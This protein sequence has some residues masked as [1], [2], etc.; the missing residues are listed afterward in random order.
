M[1]FAQRLPKYR[2]IALE[3]GISYEN[4]EY[5]GIL[6]SLQRSQIII[7]SKEISQMKFHTLTFVI[8]T[9][10]WEIENL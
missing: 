10:K 8:I 5:F 9:Y 6:R 1:K 7:S 2:K 3:K 4:F